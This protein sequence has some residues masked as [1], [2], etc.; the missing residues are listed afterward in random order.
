[1]LA[2]Q[3]S[4]LCGKFLSSPPSASKTLL[5]TGVTNISLATKL[6][7]IGNNQRK[8]SFII[9]VRYNIIPAILN[10]AE[11]DEHDV[12]THR[13]NPFYSLLLDKLGRAQPRL[14]LIKNDSV[15]S[16]RDK[17][18]TVESPIMTIQRNVSLI[19]NSGIIH[20]N[21]CSPSGKR[22]GTDSEGR[23]T[24]LI[25]CQTLR[26]ADQRARY[27]SSAFNRVKP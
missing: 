27:R 14:C 25:F 20:A 13:L 1:M 3:F 22:Q 17:S 26:S 18:A 4:R 7:N 9:V 8:V 10:M 12:R 19:L 21:P 16:S 15:S 6:A 11:L 2:R 23:K 24:S 5:A